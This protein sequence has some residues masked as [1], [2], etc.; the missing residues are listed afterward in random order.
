[1]DNSSCKRKYKKIYFILIIALILVF[2]FLIIP[3]YAEP[4]VGD[5]F[6]YSIV[7]KAGSG[8]GEYS[9]YTDILRSNGKYEITSVDQTRVE[10]HAVYS[11]TYHNSEGLDQ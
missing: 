2:E 3:V 8:S 6:E 1:M 4:A 7:R 11:W 10:F 9:G 5:S